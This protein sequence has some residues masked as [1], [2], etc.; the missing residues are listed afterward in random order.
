MR[1]YG[2]L[3]LAGL[4]LR[5][6]PVG[7]QPAEAAGDLVFRGV[8]EWEEGEEYF[9]PPVVVRQTEVEFRIAPDGTVS[10]GWD[11]EGW[12]RDVLL[13]TQGTFSGSVDLSR[14]EPIS[15]GDHDLIELSSSHAPDAVQFTQVSRWGRENALG[16]LQM[17]EVTD[18]S[19]GLDVELYAARAPDSTSASPPRS[20]LHLWIPQ[21]VYLPTSMVLDHVA[22]ELPPR[23][24]GQEPGP[25]DDT[26]EQPDSQEPEPS[27]GATQPGREATEPN[28]EAAVAPAGESGQERR[29]LA[30]AAVGA[31]LSAAVVAVGAVLLQLVQPAALGAPVAPAVPG[32]PATTAAPAAGSAPSSWVEAAGPDGSSTRRETYTDG[33]VVQRRVAADGHRVVT[34]WWPDG[35]VERVEDTRAAAEA[36]AAEAAAAEAAEAA[37]AEAAAEEAGEAAAAEVESGAAE[38]AEVES[39]AAEAAADEAAEVEVDREGSSDASV[40]A[41]GRELRDAPVV[42]EDRVAEDGDAGAAGARGDAD[43]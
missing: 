2:L 42:T 6:A 8:V 7:G 33:R 41:S 22:G 43:P 25:S 14:E 31:A 37:A 15:T 21:A 32:A 40:D 10:G 24:D 11:Y 5:A 9:D 19:G 35:R 4:G 28:R 27:P 1:R 17:H 12:A 34:Q 18:G 23:A 20:V 26:P 38:A 36:A 30:A 16:E 39:G 29:S 13:V 3:L